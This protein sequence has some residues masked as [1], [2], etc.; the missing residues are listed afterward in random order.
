MM[1]VK[2]EERVGRGTRS[3]GKGKAL[4]GLMR[5]GVMWQIQ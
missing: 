4:V 3:I 2:A 5:G 1:S